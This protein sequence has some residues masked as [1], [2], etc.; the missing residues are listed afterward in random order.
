MEVAVVVIDK[1]AAHLFQTYSDRPDSYVTS[2]V[3]ILPKYIKEVRVHGYWDPTSAPHTRKLSEAA[4]D[5]YLVL[6]LDAFRTLGGP[7]SGHF[8]H[9]GR[10]GYVGGSLGRLDPGAAVEVGP[11]GVAGY[12]SRAVGPDHFQVVK[13]QP[14]DR[15]ATPTSPARGIGRDWRVGPFKHVDRFQQVTVIGVFHRNELKALGGPGSGYFGHA[16]RP[17]EV[18]GSAPSGSLNADVG[19]E[20]GLEAPQVGQP[21]IVFRLG[22][23]EG[24]L[25]NRN[26]GNA[27]GVA[28]YIA[29]TQDFEKPQTSHATHI[30]AYEVVALAPFNDYRLANK[31]QVGP[32]PKKWQRVDGKLVEVEPHPYET[33]V[34]SERGPG[35]TAAIYNP[36]HP[37][38]AYEGHGGEVIYTFVQGGA[39]KATVLKSIPLSEIQAEMGMN[40]D[41]SGTL[42]GAKAIR[43]AFQKVLRAGGGAGSGY[44]GHA[45]RPGEVGGSA[46]SG[47]STKII[48]GDIGIGGVTLPDTDEELTEADAQATLAATRTGIG[49]PVYVLGTPRGLHPSA[50]IRYVSAYGEEQTFAPTPADVMM[51]RP[52]ECYKNASLLVF[53]RPDLTYV[54]GFMYPEGRAGLAVLHAWA[55]TKDGTVVDNTPIRMTHSGNTLY[56]PGTGGVPRYFGVTYDRAKYLKYLY[57]AKFYGVLGSTEKNAAKAIANGGRH[58][59]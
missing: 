4:A 49:A 59:R 30:T 1:A 20:T 38:P 35:R 22:R 58:L 45:G 50:A 13:E 32:P 41:E 11:L 51:G 7:G 2:R 6:S 16:G 15:L 5:L 12:I 56:R 53:E 46:P 25:D 26:A 47:V 29:N 18:G 3:T 52:N 54:E 31:G 42:A 28:A 24:G 19:D 10:P 43:H 48:S 33:E 39:W 17:G 55:A 23:P 36:T 44:F 40:F 57:T 21:F 9:E 27:E 34:S 37:H 8:G 14:V